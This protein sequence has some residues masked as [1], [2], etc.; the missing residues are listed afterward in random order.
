MLTLPAVP[1]SVPLPSGHYS[2]E[3]HVRFSSLAH[4]SM[5]LLMLRL[6]AVSNLVLVPVPVPVSSCYTSSDPDLHL[7]SPLGALCEGTFECYSREL[8]L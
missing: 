6:G 5:L 3:P 4:Q 2:S 7:S 8:G 1:N